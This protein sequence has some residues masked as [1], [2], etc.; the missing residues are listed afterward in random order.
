MQLTVFRRSE[1]AETWP[2]ASARKA[3]KTGSAHHR[4]NASFPSL[5]LRRADLDLRAGK[6]RGAG[7][8]R[9]GT[10]HA[11]TQHEFKRKFLLLKECDASLFSGN[12][13]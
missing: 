7:E 4:S 13:F 12:P 11:P 10:L 3:G 6:A 8:R 9:V 5:A 2:I 1:T